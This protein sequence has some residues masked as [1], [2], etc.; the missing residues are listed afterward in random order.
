MKRHPESRIALEGGAVEQYQ[1]AFEEH[2]DPGA[3]REAQGVGRKAL[4]PETGGKATA[5]SN[6]SVPASDHGISKSSVSNIRPPPVRA[7]RSM[8]S[9]EAF[10]PSSVNR[11]W[12]AAT[13]TA[14]CH[15]NRSGLAAASAM[16]ASFTGSG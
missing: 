13:G 7:Q 8:G 15:W 3:V 16:S 5:D 11:F 10:K 1:L 12:T 9:S 6:V 2:R 14:P 4:G